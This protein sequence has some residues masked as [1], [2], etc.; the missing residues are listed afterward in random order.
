MFPIDFSRI[1]EFKQGIE[2]L[3]STFD[4]RLVAFEVTEYNGEG[5]NSSALPTVK[6]VGHQRQIVKKKDA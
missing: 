1:S 2:A 5:S 4:I 3:C 6:F